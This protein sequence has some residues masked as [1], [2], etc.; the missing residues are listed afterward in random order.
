[1]FTPICLFFSALDQIG[2]LRCTL[3]LAQLVFGALQWGGLGVWDIQPTCHMCVLYLAQMAFGALQWGDQGSRMSSQP[4][5][6]VHCIRPKWPL[7][8][9]V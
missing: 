4:A 2:A 1:M 5:I 8:P 3:D 7:E 9:H 6:C